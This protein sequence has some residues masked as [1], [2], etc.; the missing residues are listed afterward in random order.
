MEFNCRSRMGVLGLDCAGSCFVRWNHYHLLFCGRQPRSRMCG[1][2]RRACPVY[3][4]SYL[5]T[6]Y[7]PRYK[8]RC[9]N[10]TPLMGLDEICALTDI[11]PYLSCFVQIY[12]K[13]LIFAKYIKYSIYIYTIA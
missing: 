8:M 13:I 2:Y 11:A 4:W 3:K 9:R 12:I 6:L 7:A 5:Q 10:C 1:I